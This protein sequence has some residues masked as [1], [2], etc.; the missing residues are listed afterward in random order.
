MTTTQPEI[1]D[2]KAYDDW[3][4]CGATMS[5]WH[6][7]KLLTGYAWDAITF[8]AMMG[9][10]PPRQLL[11][12]GLGGGTVV[13]QLHH[14][15]PHLPITAIE[16]DP[17][18]IQRTHRLL[19]QQL[20]KVTI[21]E[22]DAYKWLDRCPDVFPVIVDDIYAPGPSDVY[23]PKAVDDAMVLSLARC[24]AEDGILVMNFVVSGHHT[25]IF[26]D[27]RTTL[28]RHFRRVYQIHPA[29]GYNI[30]LVASNSVQMAPSHA[31]RFAAAW[32]KRDRPQWEAI[33]AQL[34]GRLATNHPR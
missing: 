18:A 11:L 3:I 24:L 12:L 27:A 2:A 25:K 26:T 10:A 32:A 4:V 16:L 17:L 34:R 1:Q 8:G 13:R 22:D 5:S 33:W 29:R 6:S 9:S 15:Q 21:F 19:A 20:Q 31:H 30:I 7:T 28:A 14:L 23:R